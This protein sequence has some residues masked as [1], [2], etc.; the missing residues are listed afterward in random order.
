MNNMKKLIAAAVILSAVVLAT[1]AWLLLPRR[2]TVPETSQV[3]NWQD[4]A[5]IVPI[6][7]RKHASTGWSDAKDPRDAV[8]QAVAMAREE[9][10]GKKEGMAFVISTKGYDLEAVRDELN[11]VLLPGVK[12]HGLV[13]AAEVMTE[14]G[15]LNNPDGSL[16][17]LLVSE[18]SGI[19]FGVGAMDGSQ[20]ASL[21]ELGEKTMRRALADSGMPPNQRPD[22]VLFAGILHYGSEMRILDGIAKVVGS[23]TPV[24]GGNVGTSMPSVP[25]GPYTRERF[26]PNGLIL[27]AVY[28]DRTVGYA[29]EYG[30]RPTDTMG[31]V[32]K[33]TPAGDIIYEIDGRPALDVYNEWLNG[34]L[35]SVIENETIENIAG[36]TACNPISR[37]LLPGEG[38][39]GYVVATA[40]PTRENLKDRALPMYASVPEG[41]TIRLMAG[42]WQTLLNRAEQAA[43]M[44]LLRGGNR[45]DNIE[46]GLLSLCWAASRAIPSTEIP[47]FPL[48]VRNQI[49]HTPFVGYFSKG[50]QGP[51]PGVRNIHCNLVATM[52]L[53]EQEKAAEPSKDNQA[54]K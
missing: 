2:A 20:V 52:V 6:S 28:T 36:Y 1:V 30:F 27:T 3:T 38:R 53:V 46:F 39:S 17:V 49:P 48:L 8:Q 54:K 12:I 35:I 37:P 4:S 41:S 15:F 22:I 50:E 19:R 32:T 9:L 5:S 29:F 7:E 10:G 24:V 42:R 18:D 33:G 40:I 51:L 45:A 25:E 13:S 21:E 11:R 47:K 43:S 14:K 23:D 26:Y 44:A 16:V 31:K 34:K